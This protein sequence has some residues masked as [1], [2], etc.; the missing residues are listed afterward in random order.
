MRKIVLVL[1][2]AAISLGVASADLQAASNRLKVTQIKV[3]L[4]SIGWCSN[5]MRRSTESTS[6]VCPHH[7]QTPGRVTTMG[8]A[9][10]R[11][12]QID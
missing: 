11:L 7:Q 2:I 4:T 3:C 12:P 9:V 8:V 5:F 1:T 6:C 10:S